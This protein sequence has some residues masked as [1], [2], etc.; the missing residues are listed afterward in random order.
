MPHIDTYRKRAKLLMRWHREGNY[1][2][3]GLVRM[4]PRLRGTT[5]AA[6]LAAPFPLALAQQVVAAEAGYPDWAALK[7]ASSDA[8]RTPRPDPGDPV[9]RGAVPILFVRDVERAVAYYSDQLGFTVDFLHGNPAFY[10][11]VSRDG[12]CLH[13]RFVHEPCF[14]DFSAREGGLILATIEVTNV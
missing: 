5:D 8:S 1:S 6:V 10:A 3:G 7:A 14:A 2:L 12:A 4:V 11:A 9:V 13:L